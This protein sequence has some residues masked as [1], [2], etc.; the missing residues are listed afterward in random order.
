MSRTTYNILSFLVIGVVVLGGRYFGFT[1]F[2]RI[3]GAIVFSL[4]FELLY[5]KKLKN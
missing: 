3:I 4:L 2:E 5:Q 1:L